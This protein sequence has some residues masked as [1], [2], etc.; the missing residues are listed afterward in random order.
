MFRRSGHRPR[1]RPKI[2][3]GVYQQLTQLGRTVSAVGK[4][5]IYYSANF[6]SYSG[7]GAWSKYS[8][9]MDQGDKG[10]TMPCSDF[11]CKMVNTL[12]SL[13]LSVVYLTFN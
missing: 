4:P 1:K 6:S 13:Q 9:S 8:M 7:R 10:G 11:G 2:I 5:F 12:F 3:E